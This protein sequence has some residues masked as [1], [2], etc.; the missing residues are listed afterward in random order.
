M[1]KGKIRG[2]EG[3]D[4]DKLD[5][6]VGDNHDSSIVVVIHQHNPWDGKYDEDKVVIGCESVEEAIGLYKK[7]Y[8]KPGF[9]REGEHTAMPIG[10]FWR[11]VKDG[12]NKGKRVSSAAMWKRGYV[13]PKP[14]AMNQAS[15]VLGSL[16]AILRAV[17]WSHTTS[18]W[19]V[20]GDQSYGDHQ[21][22]GKLYDPISSEVDKLAEKLVA[23]FGPVSVDAINQA[24]VLAFVLSHW[25]VPDPFERG[26]RAEQTLQS[27]IQQALDALEDM[28]QLSLGMDDLLRTM[29]NDHET[30]LYLLQQRQGGIRMA[31]TQ[32]SAKTN[33]R[34]Q[35]QAFFGRCLLRVGALVGTDAA[36]IYAIGAEQLARLV[37]GG[38]WMQAWDG[39]D[40]ERAD[41]LVRQH[42]GAYFHTGGDGTYDVKI[43]TKEG[44]MPIVREMGLMQPYGTEGYGEAIKKLAAE[45]IKSA[46]WWAIRPGEPGIHPNDIGTGLHNG[47]GPADVMDGAINDIVGLYEETWG[48]KP[49]MAELDA[50]WGF[51]ANPEVLL[52]AEANSSKMVEDAR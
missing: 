13:E 51:C 36:N 40:F 6:Y 23:S 26:L 28:G 41:K 20:A 45:V 39:G 12:R 10:A 17:A 15:H 49:Y 4:G 46:G 11:W 35:R 27:V 22:F 2:T 1:I 29:A 24:K 19:Q 48:R 7:Q 25:D 5:V 50:V 44:D 38:S 31:G 47:D 34:R 8:D 9:Y 42:G 33:A 52:D 3:V 43:P 30:H 18:H 32:A 21:L 37:Q 14:G 16:L